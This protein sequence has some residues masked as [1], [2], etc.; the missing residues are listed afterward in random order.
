MT[1]Y[2]VLLARTMTGEVLD[3]FG[4]SAGWTFTENL[5]FG[6]LGKADVTV[7]L[8]GRDRA[9]QHRR[10]TLRACADGRSR[11]SVC[12]V[13]DRVA[14]W[15]GPVTGVDWNT[16]DATVRASTLQWIL[17]RRMLMD[18]AYLADPM[19]PAA[20][21]TYTLSRRDLALAVLA[22]ATSGPRRALPLTLP[23][24]DG[25]AGLPVTYRGVDLRT[26]LEELETITTEEGGPDLVLQPT[27]DLTL[28]TIGWA[29]ALGSPRLG[30][31]NPD[32]TWDVALTAPSGEID[33]S[34]TVDTGYILGDELE[35][36]G[37]ERSR[38]VGV[39]QL[40]RADDVPALERADRTQS[41]E[42]DP[43][44][45]AAQAAS[46]ANEYRDA[47][48]EITLAAASPEQAP[49]YRRA[50]NL[51]DVGAFPVVDHP[52]LDDTTL[53]RRIV[54]ATMSPTSLDIAT[55]RTEVATWPA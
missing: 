50:W 54:S 30:G 47:A 17:E 4:P 29:A 14:L 41:S 32:A 37:D 18:P 24:G 22:L 21:V 15:A 52:W 49:A 39:A 2:R 23:A 6:E 35:S 11:L 38:A 20:D 46:W 26:A 27:V 19:N 28:S 5:A 12:I 48:E 40:E 10:T 3:E 44:R 43:V 51:G 1:E 36:S 53:I 31:I 42:T 7:P 13:A 45:L 33:D 9:G 34:E 16:E 8:P 25:D 55:T